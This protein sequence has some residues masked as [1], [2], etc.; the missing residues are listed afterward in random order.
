MT[1]VATPMKE[2]T[3]QEPHLDELAINQFEYKVTIWSVHYTATISRP[4][5]SYATGNFARYS[6]DPSLIH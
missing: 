2:Q 1:P 5:I 4:A 3:L 6:V